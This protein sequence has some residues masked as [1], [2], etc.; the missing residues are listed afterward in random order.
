ML[1]LLAATGDST[2]YVLIPIGPMVWPFLWAFERLPLHGGSRPSI[3]DA[4]SRYDETITVQ[5]NAD[6]LVWL[7]YDPT[8]WRSSLAGI[9]GARLRLRAGPSRTVADGKLQSSWPLLLG[10]IA[11]E[12]LRFRSVFPGFILPCDPV[13]KLAVG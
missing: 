5:E 7:R 4:A 9:D 6:F 12:L 8:C 3:S 2:R 10:P 13:A 11:F 1:A